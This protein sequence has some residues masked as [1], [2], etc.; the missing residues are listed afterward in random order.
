MIQMTGKMKQLYIDQMNEEQ[1][2]PLYIRLAE[3]IHSSFFWFMVLLF[4]FGFIVLTI[5]ELRKHGIYT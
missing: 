2:K 3:W 5:N 4:I 1:D